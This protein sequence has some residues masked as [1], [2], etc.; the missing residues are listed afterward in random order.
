MYNIWSF[1]LQTAVVSLTALLLLIIKQ[2]FTDKLSPRWQYGIWIVLVLRI[3]IPAETRNTLFFPLAV[4][5]EMAKNRAES[6]LESAWSSPLMPVRTVP[7][8]PSPVGSA[9]IPSSITDWLLILYLL[10]AVLTALRYLCS[11]IRLRLLLRRGAPASPELEEA[12]R[13]VCGRYRLRPCRA[14]TIEGL[15]TPFICGI[16]RP[17][18]AVPAGA[19]PAAQAPAAM[20]PDSKKIAAEIPDDKILLHELLHLKYLDPLQSFFWAMLRCLHWCN[21]F[22]IYVFNRIGNDMESLCD[23]RVLE[24]LEGEEMRAYGKILLSMANDR[25]ARCPGTSS[26]SNGGRNISRR[27]EA[28]ARFRKY[29]RGMGL[30]SVCIVLII[31]LSLLL[32]NRSTAGVRMLDPSGF[33]GEERAMAA[34]RLTRCSTPAGALDTYAKGLLTGDPIYMAIASPLSVQVRSSGGSTMD[35]GQFQNETD[36]EINS[37]MPGEA[38]TDRTDAGTYGIDTID[39]GYSVLNLSENRNGSLDGYILLRDSVLVPVQVLYEDGWRVTETGPHSY[40]DSLYPTD[41]DNGSLTPLSLLRTEGKTG[42]VEVYF[43]TIYTVENT[44]MENDSAFFS[45]SFFDTSIKPDAQFD[46]GEIYTTLR[47]IYRD[48]GIGKPENLA[49]LISCRMDS[50]DQEPDFPP[51]P[52]EAVSMSSSDG[53]DIEYLNVDDSWDGTAVTSGGSWTDLGAAGNGLIYPPAAWKVRILWDGEVKE[54]L[55]LESS[56]YTG[57]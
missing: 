51:V 2:I 37:A 15:P 52:A 30:V 22:L 11:Y 45:D 23:Q 54:E 4:W 13:R 49:G 42:T 12:L 1:L 53:V 17:V 44:I 19:A 55:T 10:G 31:G 56:H 47:Y 35:P 43:Y 36:N 21:P 5:I 14:V 9:G 20:I 38:Y 40:I 57:R 3:L 27:I 46:Y 6:F 26:I 18:L 50:P 48:T 32:E 28:I 39:Q 7:D 8:I 25:Y 29:P 24:R 34:A 33:G 41:I 16:I